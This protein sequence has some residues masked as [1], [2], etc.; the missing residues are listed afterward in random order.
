MPGLNEGRNFTR[1]ALAHNGRY[2][3]L[4]RRTEGDD[5]VQVESV[6]GDQEASNF[7]DSLESDEGVR[8]KHIEDCAEDE[9]DEDEPAEIVR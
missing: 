5:W 7:A 8:S 9:W 2:A 1:I 6:L 4:A 3:V